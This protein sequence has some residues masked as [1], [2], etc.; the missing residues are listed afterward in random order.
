MTRRARRPR[1]S[2]PAS[3]RAGI[4]RRLREL[5]RLA[6]GLRR[7]AR[8]PVVERVA[9]IIE[10]ECH[11]ALWALG[12]VSAMLPETERRPRD[13]SGRAGNGPR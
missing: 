8:A 10:T 9:Q 2:R 5:R 12:E 1:A 3:D 4:V 11:L 13:S 7:T 6:R